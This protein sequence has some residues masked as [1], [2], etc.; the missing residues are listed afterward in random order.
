MTRIPI[1][2]TDSTGGAVSAT[3]TIDDTTS[4]VKD[5][6]AVLAKVCNDLIDT[7]TVLAQRV[8]DLESQG[9]S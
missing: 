3:R 1:R 9:G 8:V 7:V 5:D 6:L 2:I 4:S